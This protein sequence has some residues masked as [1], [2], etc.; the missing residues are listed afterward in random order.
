MAE[1]REIKYINK[2]FN[3]YRN[4][5]IE[6]AKNYFPDTYNDFSPASP[7]MMFIEMASYVGDVL[8]FYQDI[9]LQ[10]T[11]VQYAKNPENLYSLAYM[12]GYRPKQTG[13]AEVELEVSMDLPAINTSGAN[14]EPNFLYAATIAENAT[15]KA[16]TQGQP[17]FLIDKQVDFSYSS[18]LDPSDITVKS[19]LNGNPSESTI[20]K[21]VKAFSAE[22]KLQEFQITGPEKFRTLTI[23]DDDIVGVLS[24]VDSSGHEYY[25]VPYLGQETIFEEEANT[26]G[27]SD[28]VPNKIILR[29]VPRRFVSRF[30]SQGQLVLQFGAGVSSDDDSTIVPNPK[31]VGIGN[32]EGVRRI[33]HTYDPSNFLFTRTYGLA[34][35]NTTLFVRYL[36]GGGVKANVPAGTITQQDSVTTSAVYTQYLNTVAFT[37]P[38]PA[39]GGKDKDSVEEI[40]Q[41]SLRAYNEQGRAVTV[42]D[43]NVRAQSLP[44]KFGTVAKTFVTQDEATQNETGGL[45]NSNPFAL[46]LYVLAYDSAGRLVN[47]T[48]NLKQN[49]KKYL[50]EYMMITDVLNIK[51]AFVVNI[52]INYEILALPNYSGRQ[53]LLDCSNKLK[54][55]FDTSNRQINQPINLATINTL[56]DQ[57]T[58]VQTV[59]KVE[60][61][62]KVGGLYSAFSYDVKGATRNNV[63][64]P[65]YD[66]CIFEVKYPDADIKGRITTV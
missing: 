7:G 50:S 45:V 18:S 35:S 61:V 34:P 65:S 23:D 25:E 12:L 33:D 46:S 55:Y 43:Y 1:T 60:I 24:I 16:T 10:E 36:K 9:Q 48:T 38:T 49:L 6:F 8:S 11:F 64:Y 47:A 5:L 17:K 32:S 13:V 63:V 29:K 39:S 31:N 54:E 40:R 53:V 57:V 66:P 28:K 42:Q 15:V 56:L 14:Y 27:D 26:D 2:N 21:K 62:N 41:N 37:N 30:N 22:I 44:S 58:G 19:I 59:Q 52:G 51:D 4:Q 3:D 20:K